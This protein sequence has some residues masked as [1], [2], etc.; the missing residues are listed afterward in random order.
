MDIDTMKAGREMD[1]LI[2]E[3][4]MG[5]KREEYYL[6]GVETT[7]L[8]GPGGL[9]YVDDYPHYSTDIGAAWQVIEKLRVQGVC[10][11]IDP[12]GDGYSVRTMNDE[13]VPL[14]WTKEGHLNWDVP[15]VTEIEA[16]APLAICRAALNAITPPTPPPE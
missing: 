15:S 11:R 16:A 5:W 14:S 6:C 3:K 10:L 7:G 2:A 8:V 9:R 13:E 1:A 12:R 4:A